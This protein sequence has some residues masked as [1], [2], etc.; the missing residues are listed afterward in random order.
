MARCNASPV[1]DR[2]LAPASR[3][4]DGDDHKTAERHQKEGDPT[5]QDPRK[6]QQTDDKA[7]DVER[8]K[9]DGHVR[10]LL[11]EAAWHYRRKP[12]LS[13]ALRERSVGISPAVC[14]IAWKAQSR[15]H[16]RLHRLTG[17]GKNSAEAV[18]AVA[19][20]L[21]GFVWA[22]AREEVLLAS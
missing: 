21:A 10:R 11:V 18:T 15:L 5:P 16:N 14:A 13:K 17:R 1:V 19:R 22:I 7:H 9:S 8:E 20:E 4:V 6:G 2:S 12:R 3:G